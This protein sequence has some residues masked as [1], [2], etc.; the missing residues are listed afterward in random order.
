MN[1][2]EHLLMHDSYTNLSQAETGHIQ[3]RGK[4][5]RSRIQPALHRIKH[6]ATLARYNHSRDA[7]KWYEENPERELQEEL[8][9]VGTLWEN[10]VDLDSD[11]VHWG[12]VA[13]DFAIKLWVCQSIR[14]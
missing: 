14:E 2:P 5:V 4:G 12:V 9:M 8:R 7:G 10:G 6:A 1:L 11:Y 3:G 13:W